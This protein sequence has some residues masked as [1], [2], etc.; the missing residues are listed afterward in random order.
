MK[1]RLTIAEEI[2]G[3]SLEDGRYAP[4]PGEDLHSKRT[5]R[6]DFQVVLD[7]APTAYCFHGSCSHIVE[8]FN[9]KLRRAIWLEENGDVPATKGSW[10][11]QVAPMP[12]REAKA[13][14][15][16]DDYMVWEATRGV[17]NVDD[18]WFARRSPIDLQTVKGPGDFLAHLYSPN[19]RVLVFTSQ[20]SQGD[21]IW[22]QGAGYRL[23]QERG[24]KA[25]P[26]ELP[27]R[28]PE[29]VWYLVQPVTG[30]WVVQPRVNWKDEPPREGEDPRKVREVESRYTRRSQ[31]NVTD[32]RHFVLESDELDAAL[33]LKVLAGLAFPIVA[34][35]TSGGRSIHAL[36]RWRVSG[37]A[38]WDAVR[39]SLR[40]IVCPLG[41]D[42]AALSAVR[43]SRL[44]GC[45]R[46]DRLQ[47][48]LYLN[49]GAKA[50]Q[51]I[52]LLPEL[53]A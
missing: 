40:Q 19:E 3:C 48:L 52:Q 37:K 50:G 45:H 2:L 38:E 46:G 21:F 43:L 33:W 14:P 44:P 51:T 7:G 1:S 18:R 47:R 53:R 5:G 15:D 28:G 22:W 35:Y 12:K 42:P 26:S 17:P 49:P 39:N 29:G 20:M 9:K 10:G 36:V 8:E 31:P 11:E 16:V 41:A 13:R 27:T 24:V 25:R 23:A 4:C 30:Q 34:I 32:W 6:R